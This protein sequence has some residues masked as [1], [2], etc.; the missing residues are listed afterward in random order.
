MKL[1][2]SES[3][4]NNIH[5]F[6]LHNSPNFSVLI[7]HRFYFKPVTYERQIV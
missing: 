4:K 3:R 1:T 6:A 7:R 2:F 5:I